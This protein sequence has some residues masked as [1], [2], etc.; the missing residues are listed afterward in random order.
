MILVQNLKKHF[1]AVKAVDGV[2]F[3]IADGRITGLLGP[4]GSG[5]TTT[6]RM[7]Y[8]LLAP[9]QGQV[10]VDGADA[11]LEPRNAKAAMG[12]VPDARGLYPHL[13]A[14]ENIAYYGE[15][16][17]LEG[18]ALEQRIENL[19]REL[20]MQAFLDR[21]CKG[22]SQGQRAKVAIAR[23][24][25]GDPQN[26]VLDEPGNGL[27]VMSNRGLRQY[28]RGQKARGKA[29]LLS[30]HIMQEVAALCDEVIIINAGRVRATGSPEDLMALAGTDNIEDA[31]VR[32]IGTDEGIMA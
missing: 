30:T 17:G 31:F 11:V 4:N 15:L 1:G 16:Q 14:R 27:D 28:L 10:Q 21:P 23:A 18:R 19:A 3:E 29:V 20:D 6:L 12:V 2:S 25:V 24:F 9:D 13:T 7:L 5:K 8:G 26:L 32:L 22:F